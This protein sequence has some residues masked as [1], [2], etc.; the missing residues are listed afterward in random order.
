MAFEL[1][2]VLLSVTTFAASIAMLFAILAYAAA[3]RA[4]GGVTPEETQEL[5]RR[6]GDAIR[7]AADNGTG[8]LRQ[9]VGQT[10]ATHHR[11]VVDRV[12]QSSGTLRDTIEARMDAALAQQGNA[13]HGLREELSG[14]FQRMRQGVGETLNQASEHQKERLDATQAALTSLTELNKNAGEHFR[15]TVEGRLDVMRQENAEKLEEVRKTVDEKLND[16]L[17]KRLDE[18][19]GRVIEQLERAREA[20]GE[21]RNISSHVGDL[22]N[23]LTNPKLRGTFG[24]VQLAMLLQDFLAPGQY[25]KDAQVKEGSAERVEYA[26]RI[27]LG[28]GEDML[29]PVDAKFPREDHEHMIAAYEEGD[30][31]RA[32]FHRKQLENR[33]K[34][35]AK[36]ISR[37]YI[38]SPRTTERAILF[39]PTE[40]LYAEV[41][42]QPGLF[43]I[44]Y[45]DCKVMLAGPTTFSA[46]LHAFQINHRS[47]ALASK[48]AEVWKVLSAVR[49]E[50]GK[51][52]DL[53]TKVGAQVTRAANSF[54]EFKVRTKQVNKALGSVDLMEDDRSATELL[55]LPPAPSEDS[56]EDRVALIEKASDVAD[57]AA[58]AAAAGR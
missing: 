17:N 31:A 10:L 12:V 8:R 25:I 54:D 46:I 55:G 38:N 34:A 1:N 26:I 21:L 44:L 57:F 4:G 7:V 37:K 42:R 47:M 27:P 19:F 22:R 40:S 58:A 39:L 45:R 28:N 2:T 20:F 13:A 6:E 29:L 43:E 23:M 41:L 16:T 14:S 50:F 49:T 5:L 9:E 35:F 3:R 52:N 32:D 30:H 15:L 33:I 51:Y 24:E 18:S 36:D 11:D 53:V 56:D 48:S